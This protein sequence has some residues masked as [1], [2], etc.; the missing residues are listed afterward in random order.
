MG[1]NINNG[2]GCQAGR[3]KIVDPNDFSGFNSSSNMSVPLED[4]NISVVLKTY[5]KGRT[6]LS[7][8][9]TVGTTEST[10][11][12]SI[13]FIEGS[14][15]NGKKVLTTKYTDLTTVF[16]NG[17]VNNETLGITNIDI[18]FNS[19]YAPM[20]TIN[21]IDV[22]GSSIF[23]NDSGI[24]D[25]GSGNKYSTFFQIPYPIFELEVKGY[26]GK[27]V[28]YCLH[29][30]KFN[31]KFNSQTGN[32]EMQCD[33]I[34]YTYAML[35]DLLMGYLKAIPF[36]M[37]GED[38]YKKYNENR[39]DK[40]PILTLVELMQKISE[41]NEGIE[42]TTSDS[43]NAKV[44]NASKDANE[45]L[46]QIEQLINSMGQVLENIPSTTQT[47]DKYLLIT[48]N[49][50]A[51][52]NNS[53]SAIS[54]FKTSVKTEID[55]FNELD[56]GTSLINDDFQNF[57]NHTENGGKYL[58]IT[59]VMLNPADATNDA[60]LTTKVGPQ[61]NLGELKTRLNNYLTRYYILD[62]KVDITVYN[63]NSLFDKIA[64]SRSIV[65]K[66]GEEAKKALANELKTTVAETLGF[67][68]TVRNV[69]EIFTA[70][71]EVF[72]ETIY[73]VSTMAEAKTNVDR[74]AELQKKF[75]DKK[76]YDLPSED[77]FFAWP[78]YKEKEEKIGYV[79]KYLGTKGVL[80][81]PDKVDELVFIDDL[82]QAFIKAAK[83]EEDI[84]KNLEAE[85]KV[86]YPINPV[87]TKKY[88][89]EE[90]YTRTE[91][92]N[93]QDVIRLSVIRGMTYLAYTNDY[94]TLTNEEI[95]GMGEAEAEAILR[96]VK[97]DKIKQA[98]VQQAKS[99]KAIDEYAKIEGVVNAFSNRVVKE[100]SGFYYYNY[101]FD[102]GTANNPDVN[103]LI[104]VNKQFG[105]MWDPTHSE[106]NKLAINEDFVFLTNYSDAY[107]YGGNVDFIDK[108]LD[109]GVYVN[110]IPLEEYT[111]IKATL[112]TPPANVKPDSTFILEKL[113]ED[114]VDNTAGYN[115]F[116][117]T[118]GIQEFAKVNCGGGEDGPDGLPMM[119]LFYGN[120][121]PN[122][123]SGKR[124]V[125]KTDYDITSKRKAAAGKT[126]FFEFNDVVIRED[127]GKNRDLFAQLISA[128]GNDVSYPYFEQPAFDICVCTS[129][130]KYR[131]A[132]DQYS[133]S[134]FGSKFYYA[135]SKAKCTYTDGTTVDCSEYSK[136]FLFLNN[137]PFAKGDDGGPFGRNEIKHLFDT[138][139]GFVH[140]PRLFCAYVGSILWRMAAYDPIVTDGKITGGGS[141]SK[142][143]I[144]WYKDGVNQHTNYAIEDNPDRDEYLLW[145]DWG[146]H[147]INVSRYKDITTGTA[148]AATLDDTPADILWRLPNQVKQ[149]FKKSFFDFVNGEGTFTKW[150]TI[151]EYLEIFKGTSSEFNSFFDSAKNALDNSSDDSTPL[152]TY[153]SN[154]N[155]R[156]G[157]DGKSYVIISPID[158]GFWD[159]GWSSYHS[160]YFFLELAGTYGSNTAMQTL[161]NAMKEEVVIVNTGHNIWKNGLDDKGEFIT[162]KYEEISCPKEVFDLYFKSL[163]NKLT[164]VGDEFTE[165]EANNKILQSIFGTSNEDTIKLILYKHC[166][167]IHDKWL[168]G[169][170]DPD[171]LM[172][173]CGNKRNTTDN[174]L[175]KKYGNLTPKFIDTFRFVSRSFED[176]GDL[177]YINPIP[178][179]DYLTENQNTCLY[180]SISSLLNANRFDFIALPTFVNFH[181]DEELKSIFKPYGSYGEAVQEGSC[182]PSFVCVY[183]GEKS[184]HLAVS[185]AEYPN[186][187]FDLRCEGGNLDKSVPED[188]TKNTEQ[189]NG[190]NYEDPV[191]VFTVKYSQQNQN[192][193]KDITLDQSE[194]TETEESLQIIDDISQKGSETNRTL[195]GQNLYNVYSLRS[196]TAQVEMM[197]NAMIQPM[198]YF[199]LDNIPMFHGAYMITRVK[200]S[201]KPNTM[202]TNFTGV[203]IKYSKTPLIDAMD[204]Y[205]S[206]LDTLDTSEAGSAGNGGISSG[207]FSPIIA[208]IKENGT[209]NGGETGDG[210]NGNIKFTKVPAI[211]GIVNMMQSKYASVEKVL[212]D[213][214]VVPLT[215]MLTDWVA[216]M[217]A[218][219]FTPGGESGSYAYITSLYRTLQHQVDLAGGTGKSKKGG[220]AT[221]GRSNHG[222]GIAVDLQ[223][224][225]KSGKI[226]G[227]D[228]TKGS[229]ASFF[230][231][232]TNP[233]YGWLMKNSYKYG[234]IN[235]ANLR[236]GSGTDEHWHFEYHGTSA[237]CLL[238]RSLTVY[239]QTVKAD[240]KQI[241]EVHNPKTKA[242][243][244]A[245]Y[246]NCDK[247]LVP[248]DGDRT[249]TGCPAL[250]KGK[251]MKKQSSY[252]SQITKKL[253]SSSAS[254]AGLKQV[255]ALYSNGA[256]TQKGIIALTA[257][258]LEG[259]DTSPER[260]NPGNIRADNGFKRFSSW[261]EGWKAYADKYLA[262]WPA[263]KVPAT[264]SAKYPK[265]Y[266]DDSNKV[267]TESGVQFKTGISYNYVNGDPITL[268]QYTNIYAPWGDANNPTNYCAAISATLNDYGY[269]HNIDDKMNTWLS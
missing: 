20:V 90:P 86:W 257:G 108:D 126:G 125:S 241:P 219:S 175:A 171:K 31:S 21:F 248:G 50:D 190:E 231:F 152:S 32:F 139:G 194:F 116:G 82:L 72:M 260:K 265:C 202:S 166:K 179:N 163:T 17:T 135:Q 122:G 193:F 110:I 8:E 159:D 88:V 24:S 192:I 256:I 49:M 58:G 176:I 18:D 160:D 47:K 46:D 191:G 226:F 184:K 232:G 38:K 157:K 218:E 149:E 204:V 112:Y 117:G 100:K 92:K 70:A 174:G 59:K 43:D 106:L 183:V 85:T 103:M 205:M 81:N 140:A 65:D 36:T 128:G 19:S 245:V 251:P 60:T 228:N 250:S 104:P 129:S 217:K 56:M 30:L 188:F 214:A 266:S 207:T 173:Q 79:Q 15:I 255:P 141:G 48:R 35:S 57:E 242:G 71:A 54:T 51:L 27:P 44:F 144:L 113:K 96:G 195:A 158:A 93:Y 168:A 109:G 222:W 212:I 243:K 169:A 150:E 102:T 11:E 151:K 130:D 215:K 73:E 185:N 167:N 136:A 211:S 98:L 145:L 162:H 131:N 199:Q 115:T 16:E 76:N 7:K 177:L 237:V 87:D 229:P 83:A 143:P 99:E 84:Q 198:M 209:I 247:V 121:L 262:N 120:I 42:K 114:V 178:I 142:D 34:G 13:N 101:I 12:V 133:F 180:D 64:E 45:K 23:Q 253:S 69:V 53:L 74:V 3:T 186:D 240:Q 181:D 170:T 254:V 132:D 29:M 138:R 249:E 62:D 206:L 6:V 234:F 41:I 28:T 105:G 25:S 221:A 269:K 261:T 52:D 147:L 203:R 225:N 154:T 68:P 165:A 78:D 124:K 189:I 91:F 95:I 153:T 230:N 33:F 55:A 224:F 161:I 39:P 208:T 40:K 196:Y 119:Y 26:Y 264:A 1:S 9:G 172:F 235:P 201:I 134:L 182:G 197:G 118:Q 259:L 107:G 227:N 216:W 137:L 164:A 80:D 123:L 252:K 4:L 268:R 14:N 94:Y 233:A 2:I 258:I 148:W 111:R 61:K 238:E 267:F 89:S 239:G 200:H 5:K 236:D 146:N 187:S 210:K 246:T 63:M 156:N 77:N 220:V 97:D 75:T 37:I 66:N 22:R 244:E 155:Y 263:G 223:M 213:E 67:D 10:K 127:I